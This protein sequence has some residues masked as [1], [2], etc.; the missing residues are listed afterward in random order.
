MLATAN[1]RGIP[2][3]VCIRYRPFMFINHMME[4]AIPNIL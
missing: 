3:W 1:D 2:I 4:D